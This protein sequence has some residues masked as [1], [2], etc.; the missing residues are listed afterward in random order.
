[1]IDYVEM[2]EST[3]APP[4]HRFEAGTPPITQAVGLAA[5]LRWFGDLDI[6]GLHRHLDRLTNQ[7]MEGLEDIERGQG[8]IRVLGPSR[9]ETRLPLVSFSIDNIHPHDVCQ[10]MNDFHGVAL[11]GGHHCAQPLHDFFDLDGTSRASLAAYNRQNDI[12][13]FLDGMEHCIRMFG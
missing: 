5:A 10:V 12:D 9:G 13:A 6:E 4:P 8:R 2:E 1:M 11:R 3:Y 7:L